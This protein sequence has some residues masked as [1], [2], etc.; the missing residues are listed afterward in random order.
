[1]HAKQSNHF[2]FREQEEF[3]ETDEENYVSGRDDQDANARSERGLRHVSGGSNPE[4]RYCQG[5]TR[6]SSKVHGEDK[7]FGESI[8]SVRE[9]LGRMGQG[10]SAKSKNRVESADV[11]LVVVAFTTEASTKEGK[12]CKASIEDDQSTGRDDSDKC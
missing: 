3:Q 1:M 4:A 11:D 10:E 2:A 6:E 7:D 12:C 5:G 9:A 8:L